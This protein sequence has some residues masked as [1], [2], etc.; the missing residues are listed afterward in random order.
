MVAGYYKEVTRYDADPKHYILCVSHNKEFPSE[1][2][3]KKDDHLGL[4]SWL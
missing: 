2:L 3:P 4:Q 1:E